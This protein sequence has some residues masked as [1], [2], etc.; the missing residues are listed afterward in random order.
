MRVDHTVFREPLRVELEFEPLPE[1]DEYAERFGAGSPTWRVQR[2]DILGRR[3]IIGDAHGFEDSPDCELISGGLNSKEPNAVAIGRQA[4]ILQWGF[5]AAPDRMT[6]SAQRV[7]LNSIVYMR[8]FDGDTPLVGR[9]QRS[10]EWL[11]SFID[12]IRRKRAEGDPSAKLLGYFY[13]RFPREVALATGG[14]PDRLQAWHDAN[15]G[16]VVGGP[17]LTFS[18]DPDLVEIGIPNH[19]PKLLDWLRRE[20]RRR[21]TD[22]RALRVAERYLGPEHGADANAALRWLRANRKRAFFSD[23][24]GYRWFERPD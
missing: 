14:D 22:A 16:F 4:N 19:Q 17:D 2:D 7:F 15:L 6:P 20:L 9:H 10:R 8:R 1:G 21:P 23:V 13:G 5:S 18:I 24:G 11:Q 3:G 12:R